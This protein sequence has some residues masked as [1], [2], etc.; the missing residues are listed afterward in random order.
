MNVEPWQWLN[1]L[2]TRCL[3]IP[4]ASV[5]VLRNVGGW[6]RFQK[7]CSPQIRQS[8]TSG[9]STGLCR[10]PTTQARRAGAGVE[11]APRQQA[12]SEAA[13][14]RVTN[15]LALFIHNP[16]EKTLA[17][18]TGDIRGAVEGI[19]ALTR[20]CTGQQNR[21]LEALPISTRLLCRAV[22]E[23]ANPILLFCSHLL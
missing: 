23:A 9:A 18:K 10:A 14:R 7:S 12:T 4:R 21:F 17:V 16:R 1:L 11:L 3:S 6:R 5:S 13:C 20:S 22:R 19:S 8:G 15:S 2:G